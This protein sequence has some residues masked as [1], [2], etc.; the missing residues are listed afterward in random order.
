MIY[1]GFLTA[2]KQEVTRMNKGWSLDNVTLH[3]EVT[4]FAG[5]E[6][7]SPPDV[8]KAYMSLHHHEDLAKCN[9]F[10]RN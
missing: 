2:M 1:S 5:D 4:R 7:K 8:S 10:K 3:N 6:I 9:N